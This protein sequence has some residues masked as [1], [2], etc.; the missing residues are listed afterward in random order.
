MLKIS[1]LDNDKRDDYVHSEEFELLNIT[2]LGW[3][4]EPITGFCY[5]GFLADMNNGS[6]DF[7]YESHNAAWSWENYASYVENL[8]TEGMGWE[9]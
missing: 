2:H 6:S 1:N 5:D 4:L 7:V 8:C 9:E 3:C